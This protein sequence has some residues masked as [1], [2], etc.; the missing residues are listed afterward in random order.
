MLNSYF[1]SLDYLLMVVYLA[2]LVGLGL[3]FKSK[4]STSLESYILGGRT[5]PWWIMGVS[6][7]AN[8]L[9]LSGTA[10][11]ISFIY[12]LGPRGLFIEFRG[13]ACLILVFLMLWTGKWHRRSGCL[14]AAEWSIFRF[15]DN[16]GGRFAEAASVVAAVIGSV[17]MLAY[18]IIGLGSFMSMFMPFPPMICAVVLVSMATVYV[19]VSGF[20]GVVYTDIFQSMIIVVMVVYV[21][22]VAFMKVPD[23][24]TLAVLSERITG[25]PDWISVSPSWETHMPQGYE[26][27]THLLL[28]MMFYLI[29]N[30]FGGMG[31]GGDPKY[32]GARN[33]RDCGL[34][35]CWWTFLMSFRWPMML[36]M[37]VLGLFVVGDFFPDLAVLGKA[38]ALIHQHYPDV[39]KENWVHLISS[40]AYQPQQHSADLVAS[41]QT[42]LGSDNFSAR[43]QMVSFEGTVNPER[44]LPLV[45]QFGI[46][47]GMRGVIMIALV[48]AALSTFGSTINAVAGMMVRNVYQR[49]L[50]KEAD[51]REL[52]F[53]SW[54][55]V[56]ILVVAAFMFAFSLR[57]IN[58]VWAWITMSLGTGL[59]VPAFL[60]LYW[61]RFN[62][63]GFF[64][65]TLG[66]MGGAIVQRVVWRDLPEDRIFFFTLAVGMIASVVGTFLTKPT[67]SDVLRRFYMKTRPFGLWGYLKR[68]LPAEEQ[69]VVSCEHRNDIIATPF[70]LL[71]QVS[72]FLV[73]MVIVIHNWDALW[74][75]LSLW[76]VGVV[77]MYW[78]WYR[79]LPEANWYE[80]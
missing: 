54:S 72:M 10:L 34:L 78:F 45:L 48:A 14:T 26:V 35:T 25:N 15:G 31:L 23:S 7:M 33:D 27:Y 62:G 19:M 70:A 50:R 66:G 2:V 41:L 5:I 68:E 76:G 24:A 18:L 60:R 9:D 22:I 21:S 63:G 57:S 29:R 65:G 40:L 8:M 32:F 47:R 36:G 59:M 46:G 11:I 51:N 55:S 73:P 17:G 13:G 71:W 79:N 69:K 58:D 38:G 6:G 77:G 61:W 52:I 4:A 37:A 3:H 12:L 75:C 64:W 16:M 42:L 53:A 1:S 49:Y 30:I 80:K 39:V 67:D 74:W 20:Y 43:L 28:F 44:I 56:V